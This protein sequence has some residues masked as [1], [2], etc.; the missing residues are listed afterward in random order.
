MKFTSL[1]LFGLVTLAIN[2]NTPIIDIDDNLIEDVPTLSTSTFY[3][4]FDGS[5]NHIVKFYVSDKT[6]QCTLDIS[7]SYINTGAVYY[8]QRSALSDLLNNNDY[9]NLTL[10]L[11]NRMQYGGVLFKI[12]I[13]NTKNVLKDTIDI[14][15]YPTNTETIYA[16]NY[17]NKNYEIENRVFKVS[18]NQVFSK[19]VISFANTIDYITNSKS[20]YL[21]LDEIS[22]DYYSDLS[23]PNYT[24]ND[25]ISIEDNDEIFPFLSRN[26]E[27]EVLFPIS[28]TRNGN[29]VFFQN[30]FEYFY[31]RSSF[32]MYESLPSNTNYSNL[33]RTNQIYI[34]DN[35]KTELELTNLNIVINSLPRSGGK[36]V[37]P[38]TFLKDRNFIGYCDDSNHCIIGGIRE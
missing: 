28:L 8:S 38:L 15:I 14:K 11:K 22:F 37:I 6:M 23:F 7:F 3:G 17:R 29:S 36:I 19:E 9:F 31:D 27:N 10:F 25:Y 34:K 5:N 1:F 26:N 16:Y 32:E 12:K 20:N 13:Y 4:P 24:L 30:N 18:N 33:A 35:K 21:V 2:P